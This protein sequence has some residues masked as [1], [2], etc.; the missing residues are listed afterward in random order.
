MGASLLAKTAVHPTSLPADPPLS[1]ASSLPQCSVLTSDLAVPQPHVGAG[2]PAK[3]AA[4]STSL[5]AE[6]PLSRAGSLPQIDS[7]SQ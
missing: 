6:P 7:G 3:T 2:L 4:H 1:R 5:P